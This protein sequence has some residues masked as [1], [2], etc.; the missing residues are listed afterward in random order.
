MFQD[1]SKNLFVTLYC[2][3]TRQAKYYTTVV[4]SD[5]DLYLTDCVVNVTSVTWVTSLSRYVTLQ[6][7]NANEEDVRTMTTL[8]VCHTITIHEES[9]SLTIRAKIVSAPGIMTLISA[10][11]R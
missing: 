1:S 9:V 4:K 3:N 8:L 5:Q 2:A 7:D 6:D 10:N 11:L